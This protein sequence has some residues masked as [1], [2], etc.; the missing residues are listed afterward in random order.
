VERGAGEYGTTTGRPRR[1][2][3]FDGVLARYTA[4]QNGVTS[5]AL[6]RLD[7]LSQFDRIRVCTGYELNGQRVQT[8]P[9]SLYGMSNVQP[10]YED[11]PGWD[12]EVTEAR[13]MSDLPPQ[14]RAYVHRIEELIGVPVDM[15]SVGPER[16]QA[17]V[18]RNIFGNVL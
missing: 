2:G 11:L 8:M 13:A 17:I 1:T 4:R 9:A 10:I 7:V 6:T 18:T 15:I 16:D 14:A 3:W 5:V 12:G